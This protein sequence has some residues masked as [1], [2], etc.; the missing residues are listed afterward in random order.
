MAFSLNGLLSGA[1]KGFGEG[2]AGYAGVEMDKQAKLDYATKLSELQEQ[3]EI[4]IAEYNSKLKLREAEQLPVAQAKG[5]KTAAPI[6]AE[7]KV[8]GDVAELD[9]ASA[10]GLPQKKAAY[11][12][13]TL[14]AEAPNAELKAKIEGKATAAGQVAKTETKGYLK[15]VELEDLAKAAGERSVA[16][17]SRDTQFAIAS[18][19]S[20]TQDANGLYFTTMFDPKTKTTTTAALTGPDGKQLQGPKDLDQRTAKMAE[21]LLVSARTDLDA[22]S[23]AQTVSQVLDLLRGGNPQ[24]GSGTPPNAAVDML[25]RNPAL[26]EQFDAKYGAGASKKYLPAQNTK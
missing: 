17:M 5:A 14:E 2:Y 18:K 23:R 6:V 3:K 12:K 8:A 21:A 22:E 7:G 1:M 9:A 20:I 4:R 19:P 13:S 11:T 16:G 24:P 15:S 10:A 26:A 25:R